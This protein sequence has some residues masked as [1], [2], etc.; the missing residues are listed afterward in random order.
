MFTEAVSEATLPLTCVD[1]T[2]L[3]GISGAL[4]SWL[5]R[6]VDALCHRLAGFL[7]CEV[8]AAT[9]LLGFEKGNQATSPVASPRSLELYDKADL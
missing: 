5:V 9:K 8:L 4:F 1:S 6:V 3:E 2:R 7:L